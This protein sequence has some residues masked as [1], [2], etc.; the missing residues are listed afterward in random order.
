MP[1]ENQEFTKKYHFFKTLVFFLSLG[2][3]LVFLLVFY[4]AGGSFALER[5]FLDK[6]YNFWITLFLYTSVFFLSLWVINFG[7]NV[8]ESYILERKFSLSTQNFF[9]WFKDHLKTQV[10]S[11]IYFCIVIFAFY[12]F[13]RISGIY[14][15]IFTGA[16]FIAVSLFIARIFPRFIIPL[17][18]K[19]SE[20]PEGDLKS[21]IEKIL[22][23]SAVKIDKVYTVDF[24]KK[25]KKANAFICGW[26]RGRRLVLADNLLRDF[27]KEEIL[28]VVSHELA[29][30]K[31]KDIMR[32][33]VVSSGFTWTGLWFLNKLFFGASLKTEIYHLPLY[34]L[35][36]TVFFFVVQPLQNFFFR[37]FESQADLYALNLTRDKASFITMLDKLGRNNL[38]EFRPPFWKEL[39]FYTHPP[40]Y[41]RIKSIERAKL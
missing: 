29:H 10:L 21:A 25:T 8:F 38:A 11:Y 5:F 12:V 3:N 28:N 31:H 34:I 37:R 2:A 27:T 33:I 15:W 22:Q 36:F 7:F 6:G 18:Y 17:F 9:S 32:E 24:S 1:E 4:F 30:F 39:F 40:L 41:K 20:L 13:L 16:F 23:G 26:G 19:Y 14:W 35:F